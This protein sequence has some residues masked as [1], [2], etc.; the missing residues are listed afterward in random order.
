MSFAECSFLAWVSL[1]SSLRRIDM[2]AFFDE[3][4]PTIS[5][6]GLMGEWKKVE[7]TDVLKKGKCPYSVKCHDG[8]ASF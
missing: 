3:Q 5:Y 2:S 1:P 8:K 7:K 4:A 6:R